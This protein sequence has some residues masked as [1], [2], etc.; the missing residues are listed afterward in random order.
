MHQDG[1]LACYSGR[2]VFVQG[3][4][5]F[6]FD[7]LFLKEEREAWVKHQQDNDYGLIDL[8]SKD[9]YLDDELEAPGERVLAVAQSWR[10]TFDTDQ[11]TETFGRAFAHVKEDLK[12]RA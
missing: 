2:A 1:T 7:Q 12:R 4:I 6:S 8:W 3:K 9:N 5:L 11:D 10:M